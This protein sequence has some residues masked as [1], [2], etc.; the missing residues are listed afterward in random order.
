MSE[1]CQPKTVTNQELDIP[2]IPD[3]PNSQVIS[4][5]E[6]NE[7]SIL[8]SKLE[9]SESQGMAVGQSISGQGIE[10]DIP[11]DT[12]TKIAA[13]PWPNYPYNGNKQ[14]QQQRANKVRERIENCQTHNDLIKL[15]SNGQVSQREIDWL[16]GNI[17]TKAEIHHLESVEATRQGNLFNES[18]LSSN[19]THSSSSEIVVEK[20][21]NVVMSEIDAEMKRIGMSVEIAQNYLLKT[22]G[23][24]S[25]LHLKDAMVFEFLEALRSQPTPGVVS[26]LED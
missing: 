15:L 7:N 19:A 5:S 20:D 12:P 3:I 16:R 17:L 1:V 25:R 11:A 21:W 6:L 13:I 26:E 2:G 8:S 4:Q 18:G 9:P 22:Y 24:K 23:V 10:S 14:A